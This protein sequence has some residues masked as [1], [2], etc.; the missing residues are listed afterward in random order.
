MGEN[1]QISSAEEFQ[2]QE[3]AW[4]FAF[5]EVR[6]NFPFLKCG[7]QVLSSEECSIDRGEKSI[8]LEKRDK[9]YLKQNVNVNSDM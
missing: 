6:Q 5:K 4:S 3:I 7:P 8:F 2:M 1:T 9:H